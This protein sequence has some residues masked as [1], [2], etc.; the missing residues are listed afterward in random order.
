MVGY[1][2][3]QIKIKTFHILIYVRVKYYY[4][5]FNTK[6]LFSFDRKNKYFGNFNIFG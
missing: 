5:Y 6:K 3:L 1:I 4:E 2:L